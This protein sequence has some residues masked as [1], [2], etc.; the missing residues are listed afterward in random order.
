MRKIWDLIGGVHPPENKQQS[1]QLPIGTLPLPEKLV[2]PLNQHMGAPARLLVTAG[3]HVLK[4]QE[5]A[6]PSGLVSVG[7]HA[8]TSGTISDISDYPI[9][10][11]S[12]MAARCITLIPDGQEQWIDFAGIDTATYS[13]QDYSPAKLLEMIR[14]AGIAGLGGAGFPSAV[15]L[16][17]RKAITTLIINATECEP[18]ITAD[19]M[20][21][22]ERAQAIVEGIQILSYIL[23]GPEEVLIGIE[24]NK[25][26]AHAALEPFVRDTHIQLVAFPTRYP[27]GG[28]K[29]LI[30]ILTGRE[31]PSGGLPADIGIVCQNVGTA[32]AVQKAIYCGEPLISRITT[33]TGRAC[34][35][36]RNYEV[37]IGTPITHLLAHN[38]FDQ[39]NCSRLIMGGPMMGFTLTDPD[40]PVIKSTNCILAPSREESPTP[41]PAQPCIRCGMCAEAC[42]ASLLPQQLFWYAQSHNHERLEA[43]NLFDCIECGAC[44]YVCPSNI[45]LVQ[46]YRAA[47]GEIRKQAQEKIKSD[48]ARARFEF[49]K[50]RKEQEEMAKAAKREARKQAAEQAKTLAA[51]GSNGSSGSED[52][53]KAAM[54]RAAEHQASPEEQKARL[55]RGIA[56][57]E[58]HLHTV[59]KRLEAIR[60][61]GT[62][63]QQEQAQAAVEDA[64]RR[65]EDARKK[66]VQLD[67][68]AGS[69]NTDRVMDR[70]QASPRETLENKIASCEERIAATRQ[71]IADSDDESLK[72]ALTSGLE[73]QQAKLVD[74]QQALAALPEDAG[75]IPVTRET[76]DAATTAI[77]RAQARAATTRDMPTAEQLRQTVI[78]L[79]GRIEKA[80]AKLDEAKAGESEYVNAL[81]SGL[82]KLQNKLLDT[83]QQLDAIA[84][85]SSTADE[86][87]SDAASSAIARAQARVAE[88]AGMSEQDK[89]RQTVA[90]LKSRLEKARIK[91][92]EAEAERSEH[93]DSLRAAAEKLQIRLTEAEQQ[94]TEYHP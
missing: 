31:V 47:K 91:L 75:N 55:E 52:I 48:R 19:D 35:T 58:S 17:P 27:S 43:H 64:R 2:I 5:L 6:E 9:P 54:A 92:R 68:T 34:A 62:G 65:L 88:L 20:L 82:E 11:P 10:H 46:Y 33:V 25:P 38:G 24:D 53:V 89:L 57:A 85:S 94:L 66:R 51:E 86:D 72:A 15:K 13:F 87:S 61:E 12:G 78:A 56:R 83:Q 32:F 8:S 42:P 21:M 28:E 69:G 7:V 77:A 18:Y 93:V 44:S 40:I 45:P 39:D 37:L 4:G 84:S 16:S 29:Q 74:A 30:Q 1:V 26:E 60:H 90:S 71:K 36:N 14:Q 41:L 76:T 67:D 73:K 81:Q 23:G 80:K 63:Q 49:Q 3:D 59:E 22:R 79:E 50:A 70:L